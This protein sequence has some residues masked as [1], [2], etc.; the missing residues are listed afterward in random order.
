M[1]REVCTLNDRVRGARIHKGRSHE[2]LLCRVFT[3]SSG[4]CI[5]L[6]EAT[7]SE[8]TSLPTAV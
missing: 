5:S 6:C 2:A 8:L 7:L 3:Y 1:G 4:S